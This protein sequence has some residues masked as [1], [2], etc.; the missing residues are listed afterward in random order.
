MLFYAWANKHFA[1]PARLA[2]NPFYREFS[3]TL[4]LSEAAR[5]LPD[6]RDSGN[7]RKAANEE[8]WKKVA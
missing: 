2:N 5:T 7:L 3:D 1:H 4:P 6:M 8:E